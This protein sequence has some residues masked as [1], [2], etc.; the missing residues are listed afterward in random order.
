MLLS[1]CQIQM[2]RVPQ[3]SEAFWTK[4]NNNTCSY[5]AKTD[6]HTCSLVPSWPGKQIY[7]I[8]APN[9]NS[10]QWLIPLWPRSVPSR[11]AV[12]GK[13]IPSVLRDKQNWYT[14][15]VLIPCR[16]SAPITCCLRCMWALQLHSDK[17]KKFS[18][19]VCL[20][21]CF[22]VSIPGLT[23]CL[24]VLDSLI[25]PFISARKFFPANNT[26]VFMRRRWC[27]IMQSSCQWGGEREGKQA[28]KKLT[29]RVTVKGIEKRGDMFF[30]KWGCL[31][32]IPS[33]TA[34]VNCENRK[35]T[36]NLIV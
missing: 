3:P 12:V 31:C 17:A 6:T 23:L 2:K 33:A 30:H 29:S 25:N 15:S 19:L 35:S 34:A 11:L 24:C 20:S 4:Y 18:L 9:R 32:G 10:V 16:G 36:F 1:H 13:P 26:C 5:P 27:Y 28:K 21:Q 7:L 8:T 14:N 22:S